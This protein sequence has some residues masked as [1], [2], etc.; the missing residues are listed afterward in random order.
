MRT[1]GSEISPAPNLSEEDRVGQGREVAHADLV[2][3]KHR[4]TL[5]TGHKKEER[6]HRLVLLLVAGVRRGPVGTRLPSSG[7]ILVRLRCMMENLY[8]DYFRRNIE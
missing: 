8:M 1:S 4:A 6:V 7:Y 3:R 5:V 2:G